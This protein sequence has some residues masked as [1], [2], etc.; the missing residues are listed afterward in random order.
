MGI[1]YF[2]GVWMRVE[3]ILSR[4]SIFRDRNV[5]SP[6]FIPDTLLHRDREIESIV[7]ILAPSSKRM[8]PKSIFIYGKTGTGKT[9][10]VKHIMKFSDQLCAIFAYVNCRIYN[11]KYKVLQK[12][13]KT[14]I[15]ELDKTGFGLSHIYERLVAFAA[16][17]QIII[18]LDE[19]D[20]VKDVDDLLYMLGRSND[21]IIDG[22]ITIIGISNSLSFKERLDARS[23][24]SLYEDEMV[25]APYSASQIHD[26]L[27]ERSKIGFEPDV[28][29]ESALNLI[30]AISAQTS[31]DA[32]Y[33]LRLLIRAGEV[34]DSKRLKTVTDREVETA[35]MNVEDDVIIEAVSTLPEHQQ[36]L[37]LGLATLTTG[38]SSYAKLGGG[39]EGAGA[40]NVDGI[41]PFFMSGELYEQYAKTCNALGRQKRSARWYREYLTDLEMLGL[42]SMVETSTG[43]R[44]RSRLIKLCYDAKRLKPILEKSLSC[45]IAGGHSD[46]KS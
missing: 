4:P 27:K 5:L 12:V 14:F 10:T 28:V 7:R 19:I 35:R 6:H 11:S 31:G 26:I 38:G 44:G 20:M 29:Q 46:G 16:G 21:E 34:A 32:R 9:S 2:L 42:I 41:E 43:I 30:A 13:G 37:L 25:F 22:G 40:A 23:K 36:I 39:G 17:K 8:K 33:A 24:S 1:V 3:E 45:G 15:G 18:I